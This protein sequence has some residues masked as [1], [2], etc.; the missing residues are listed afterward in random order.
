MEPPNSD[1]L[2]TMT[3]FFV[4]PRVVVVHRFD[5]ISNTNSLILCIH[6]YAF[7]ILG[8]IFSPNYPNNYNNSAYKNWTLS[9][10][11]GKKIRLSIVNLSMECDCSDCN[12]D[13]NTNCDNDVYS[14]TICSYDNLKVYLNQFKTLDPT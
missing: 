7:F 13:C 14:C 2:W 11:T 8:N 12:A 3:T 6:N 4:A 9:A 1:H 10:P 5:C